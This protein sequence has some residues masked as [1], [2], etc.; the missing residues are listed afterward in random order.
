MRDW[1]WLATPRRRRAG[2][3]ARDSSSG[4][5]PLVRADSAAVASTSGSLGRLRRCDVGPPRDPAR[6]AQGRDGAEEA[7][8][9][10]VG[11]LRPLDLG[12]VAAAVEHDVLGL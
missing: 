7:A 1:T 5:R 12:H 9:E 11:L 6:A 4:G 10:A 8:E 2:R 3:L